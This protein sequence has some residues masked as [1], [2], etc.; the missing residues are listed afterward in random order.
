MKN[1]EIPQVIDSLH[2]MVGASK[3]YSVFIKPVTK[4]IKD[5]EKDYRTFQE[6]RKVLA[7]KIVECFAEKRKAEGSE[8]TKWP[9]NSTWAWVKTQLESEDQELVDELLAM[10]LKEIATL[11]PLVVKASYIQKLLETDKVSGNDVYLVVVLNV[12]DIIDD[13]PAEEKPA[14]E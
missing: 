13:L 1:I 11:E 7:D 9:Q 3:L 14:A 10:E 12:F 2:R 5:L 8:E 6:D 4:I